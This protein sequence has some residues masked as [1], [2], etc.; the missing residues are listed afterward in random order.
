MAPFLKYQKLD[1]TQD[2]ETNDKKMC[3]WY[4]LYSN[5][6]KETFISIFGE[7]MHNLV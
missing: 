4:M 2:S 5:L 1:S 6:S 3:D 7:I